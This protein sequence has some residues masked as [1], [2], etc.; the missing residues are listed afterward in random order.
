M[1]R[2]NIPD[3]HVLCR[4][5]CPD[6]SAIEE[7]TVPRSGLDKRSRGISPEVAFP[8]LAADKIAQLKDH[9]CEGCR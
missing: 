5:K 8:D 9:L 7:F 1:D 4:I 3:G 2:A 6:C